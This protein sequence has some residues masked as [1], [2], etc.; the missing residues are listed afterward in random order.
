MNQIEN[1]SIICHKL[2]LYDNE[3]HIYTFMEFEFL[4]GKNSEITEE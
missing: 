1:I 2:M 4:Y 3:C